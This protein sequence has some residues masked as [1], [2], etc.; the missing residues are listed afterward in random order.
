MGT[1]GTKAPRP[2]CRPD[3]FCAL[4]SVWFHHI[5]DTMS[6]DIVDTCSGGVH[7][8]CSLCS[9]CRGGGGP[10]RAI[11]GLVARYV[12]VLGGQ[13]GVAV[14]GRW[15]PGTGPTVEGASPPAVSDLLGARERDRDP[16]QAPGRGG[17]R[18]R[19][20]DHPV[21]PAPASRD[22]PWSVDHPPGTCPA[23]V[24]R[25]PTPEATSHVVGAGRGG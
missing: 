4:G 6:Q 2:L 10:V 9:R 12:E 22:V 7:G 24:S 21:P 11:C 17:V 13:T 16:A 25:P 14:P 5:V 23:G 3:N 1:A 15:L 8:P 18:C 19:A 20:A